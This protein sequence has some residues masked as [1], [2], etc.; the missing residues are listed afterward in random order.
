MTRIIAV[1]CLTI[2]GFAFTGAASAG[3]RPSIVDQIKHASSDQKVAQR[4][5]QTTCQTF[6]GRQV[7]NTYCY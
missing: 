1:A 2:A 4:H 5:C 6:Q 3:T 7:C